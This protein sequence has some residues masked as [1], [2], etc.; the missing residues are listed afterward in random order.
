MKHDKFLALTSEGDKCFILM[1]DKDIVER[2]F[3][4]MHPAQEP[5]TVKVLCWLGRCSPGARL[6]IKPWARIAGG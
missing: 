2:Y 6:C 3:R 5:V 1:T 4:E